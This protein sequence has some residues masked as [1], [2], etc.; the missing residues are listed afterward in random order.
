MVSTKHFGLIILAVYCA[1][2][3]SWTNSDSISL[4]KG[5]T[6]EPITINYWYYILLHLHNVKAL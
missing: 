6:I 4:T 1:S 3:L 2:A 5:K